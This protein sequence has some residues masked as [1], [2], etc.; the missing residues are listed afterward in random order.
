MGRLWKFIVYK[1]YDLT[2]EEI[3]VVEGSAGGGRTPDA[4][5]PTAGERAGR[6]REKK[7]GEKEPKKA[8]K[9]KADLPP[10]LPG[11]N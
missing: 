9:R 6:G 3:T 2:P 5:R 7:A 4:G 11:W 10:S 8:R 1:L